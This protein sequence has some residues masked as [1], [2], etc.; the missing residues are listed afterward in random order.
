MIG[1]LIFVVSMLIAARATTAGA[2]LRSLPLCLILSHATLAA[3]SQYFFPPRSLGESLEKDTFTQTW[4]ATQLRALEERSICCGRAH[5]PVT[6]R[7]TWLRTFHHPISIRLEQSEYGGGWTLTTKEACGAG[8]YDPGRLIHKR[9]AKLK[10]TDIAPVL[11]ELRSGSEYWTMSSREPPD[12][13]E[14]GT[15]T[16]RNDGAQWILEVADAHRYHFVDRWSPHSGVVREVGLLLMGL[17]DQDFGP[18]Y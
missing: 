5:K 7:F 6:I 12:P 18:V 17:T 13:P 1:Q 2:R 4:Y 14:E 3:S 16:I 9:V 8:G 15:I 10:E 11:N